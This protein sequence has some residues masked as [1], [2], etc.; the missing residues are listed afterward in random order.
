[1]SGSDPQDT[2][3]RP[4]R[5]LLDNGRLALVLSGGGARGAFDAGV[6]S[7]VYEAG[8][9]PQVL[10]GTSAGAL[11]AA[12]AAIGWSPER[13]REL[14]TDQRSR[15][16]YR[17]RFDVHRLV[18]PDRLLRDPL[19]LPQRILGLGEYTTTEWLLDLFGW[20]WLFHLEPLRAQLVDAIGG[21]VLPLEDDV[22]LVV[23][24]VDVATGEL[25]RFGNRPPPGRPADG[26]RVVE[27][28]VDHLLASAAIPGLFRPT[29][30]DGQQYW[31][32]GLASNTP[33]AA[34]LQHEP[35]LAVVVASSVPSDRPRPPKSLGDVLA[36]AVEHTFR[37]SIL[38]DLD[39]ARTV[40]D[41]V[42][43]GVDTKHQHVELVPVTPEEPISG[44][45]EILDFEPARARRLVD[46]GR[47]AVRTELGLSD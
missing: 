9:R 10:A 29:E 45:G 13:I 7:A 32:G 46:A 5:A 19:R 39:Q 33:L 12:A 4:D 25:V 28:T 20:T 41:M 2:P 37:S 23:S 40:N 16:V 30:I 38:T 6:V 42:E 24:A 35:D 18:R 3:E 43:A 34:A 21:E 15:D 47:D 27:L 8:L 22:T 31:D 17:A 26:L 44:I 36:L 1:M 11:T 14:W